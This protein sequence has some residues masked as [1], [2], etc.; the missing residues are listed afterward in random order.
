M[1]LG[2]SILGQSLLGGSVDR[3]G[4][5]DPITIT[6]P[7]DSETIA[8][9]VYVTGTTDTA[10]DVEY[11]ID[12][13]S[14]ATLATPSGGN[15]SGLITGLVAGSRTIEVRQSDATGNTASVSVTVVDDAI[16]ITSPVQ[17]QLIRRGASAT[18]DISIT[19][20]YTG[21]HTTGFQ[22]RLNRTGA[23][24]WT[25]LQRLP[26]RSRSRSRARAKATARWRCDLRRGRRSATA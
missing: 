6:S 23:E 24:G 8:N 15:Y 21:V 9:E 14:W 1:R 5:G 12:A 4:A 2:Q 18:A 22:A 20:T 11:R 25:D 19:F 26:A 10:G 17:H 7:A 3:G 13:G 16:V